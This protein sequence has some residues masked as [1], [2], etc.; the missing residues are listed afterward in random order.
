M[1][2]NLPLILNAKG[3]NKTPI[4]LYSKANNNIDISSFSYLTNLPYIMGPI[5]F[6]PDIH[7]KPL[8]ETPSSSVIVT[9]HHFSL[10]LTSPSQNCGMSLVITPI[11]GKDISNSFLK[12]LMSEIKSAIPLINEIPVLSEEEVYNV[13]TKGAKWALKKFGFSENLSYHIEHRGNLFAG[14]KL[15]LRAIGNAVPNEIIEFARYRLGIIGGGN[16]FL[17]VQIVDEIF[18]NKIAE[19]WGLKQNQMVIMFHTG[20]D[21]LGAYLGRLYAFRKK[22]KIKEQLK[23]YHRKVKH[24]LIGAQLGAIGKRLSYYFVPKPFRF[25][26]PDIPEG[27][28]VLATINCAANFGF[29]NRVAIFSAIKSSLSRISNTNDVE[30]K[31]LYDCSHNSIYRETVNGNA[32]WAHRHNACR[33]YP[34][35][36]LKKH[37]IFSATGQPVILPGTNQTSSFLCAGREGAVSTHYTVDHGLGAIQKHHEKQGLS[38]KSGEYSLLFNYADE[39]P[40]KIPRLEDTAVNKALGILKQADILGPVAR[41]KP[42]ATLKGPKSKII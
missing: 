26:D 5:I 25:I 32:V 17:E 27:K 21:A 15:E 39:I 34:P 35:S 6:L 2:D 38:K 33:V 23:F 9:H 16:H 31:L 19:V 20:S 1:N 29:A 10:G 12:R 8:L 18:D 3:G 28:R 41:L 30:N 14:N 13:L 4:L 24:H 40:E 7:Y 11:F 37:P 22:T 42:L 36:L